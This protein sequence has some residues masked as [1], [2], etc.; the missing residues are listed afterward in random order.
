MVQMY[1]KCVLAIKNYFYGHRNQ[2]CA[3]TVV[4]EFLSAGIES[5]LK[6]WNI[7]AFIE[8]MTME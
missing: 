2:V 6:W 7:V 8:F 5:E 4:A 3:P 1:S